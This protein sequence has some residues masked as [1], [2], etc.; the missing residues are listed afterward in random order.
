M[1]TDNK[2]DM[3]QAD[4]V[5]VRSYPGTENTENSCGSRSCC[6]SWCCVTALSYVILFPCSLSQPSAIPKLSYNMFFSPYTLY[7]V[8][9]IHAGHTL[10]NGQ[11]QRQKDRENGGWQKQQCLKWGVFGK[12][13]IREEEYK[14]TI[15]KEYHGQ[16]N[17]FIGHTLNSQ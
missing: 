14:K 5:I 8:M 16:A 1:K 10:H 17:S 12:A 9:V 7:T 6:V 11:I 4:I 2:K 3:K 13:E 15:S